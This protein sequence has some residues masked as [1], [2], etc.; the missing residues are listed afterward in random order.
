MITC[1]SDPYRYRLRDNDISQEMYV[2][3]ET[4]DRH[5]WNGITIISRDPQTCALLHGSVFKERTRQP[6]CLIRTDLSTVP[7]HGGAG[8]TTSS[9]S[10]GGTPV[11][12]VFALFSGPQTN[13]GRRHHRALLALS[14]T[15]SFCAISADVHR[16]PGTRS[17]LGSI[18]VRKRARLFPTEFE[19]APCSIAHRVVDNAEQRADH[20]RGADTRRSERRVLTRPSI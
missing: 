19:P 16:T 20:G 12:R 14:T 3:F 6:P 13:V 8:V 2:L 11:K 9:I 15:P 5:R 10:P 1:E 17:V 7:T 4:S 18:V